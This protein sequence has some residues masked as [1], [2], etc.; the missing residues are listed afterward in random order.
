MQKR[1][2]TVTKV[3]LTSENQLIYCIHNGENPHDS[4]SRHSKRTDKNPTNSEKSRD[5][6]ELPELDQEHL[7]K[8]NG[9][10]NP[11]ANIV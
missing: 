11:T 8:Q 2:N 9:T 6:D 1:L 3:S 4:L 7:Q 5:K 10:E